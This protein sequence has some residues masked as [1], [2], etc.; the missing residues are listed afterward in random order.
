MRLKR[1]L[2]FKTSKVHLLK[3]TVQLQNYTIQ[4]MTLN[5]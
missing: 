5:F 4:E 1:F 2:I 3:I